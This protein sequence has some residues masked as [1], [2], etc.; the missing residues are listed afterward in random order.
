MQVHLQLPAEMRGASA[1]WNLSTQIALHHESGEVLQRN[2]V[3]L[4]PVN[5]P[6]SLM[7]ITVQNA[8]L[9]S[10]A[11]DA[12]LKPSHFSPSAVVRPASSLRLN[13]AFSSGDFGVGLSLH[14]RVR[15]IASSKQITVNGPVVPLNRLRKSILLCFST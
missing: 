13:S 10:S 2:L 9:L 4:M 8:V 5:F 7:I 3:F 12:H 6:L 11:R 1:K 14:P 15:E